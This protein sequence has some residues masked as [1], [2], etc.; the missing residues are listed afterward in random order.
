MRSDLL[1]RRLRGATAMTV[2]FAAALALGGR[3]P[4]A[5]E[6]VPLGAERLVNTT[7]V[8]S[9]FAPA[10]AGEPGGVYLV[11]WQS[12]S[13]DGSGA[14]VY[15]RLFEASGSPLTGE[16]AIAQTTVGEQITPAVAWSP[17]GTFLVAWASNGQD[18]SGFGI[19][20][21]RLLATTGQAL[22]N[23]FPVNVT[24]AGSQLAPKVAAQGANFYVVWSGVGASGDTNDVYGR[25]FAA[26][27]A[28]PGAATGEV[29]LNGGVSG[30]Q[31]Q[32]AIAAAASGLVVVWASDGADGSGFGVVARRFDGAFGAL[33]PDIAVPENT[34]Y[35]QSAPA[36]AGFA[37]GGFAV[38]WQRA[39]Q[40]IGSTIGPQ[41]VIALRRFAGNSASG[42]EHQVQN[43]TSHRHEAPAIVGDSE[44]SVTVAWQEH[45]LASGDK[46]VVASRFDG[47]NTPLLL[48]FPL[49][50]AFA[51][52]QIAPALA[53]SAR[54]IAA[55][56][57]FGQDGSSFGVYARRFGV[58]LPPCAADSTTLCL[59]DNRFRVRATYATAAGANGNGRAIALT[60]DSG[61]YWFFDDA[62]VEIVVKAIDACGLA[63]FD[64]FWLFATGLTNV[65]VSLDVVDTW[66]GDER[67]YRNPLNQDFQPI[68]DTG[69]FDV[70]DAPAPLATTQ[71]TSTTARGGSS[72]KRGHVAGPRWDANQQLPRPRYVSPVLADRT[73]SGAGPTAATNAIATGSCIAN[74]TTLCLNQ[75]RFEVKIDY[76]TAAGASGD[77]Q[78]YPLT[79]DSGY[80]WFF[81]DANVEL[82]IKVIDGCGY[83]DRYWV[84][85]GGLTNVETH[86]TVRDTLHPTAVFQ[87]TNPL[88]QAFAP[89]LSIDAFDTCP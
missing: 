79:T 80:F 78:A 82:V 48:D 36:V 86:L 56:A 65:E 77:G 85:A 43:E 12:A 69:H 89:I 45:D 53:G 71:S 38:A 40:E 3:A 6:L 1:L 42:A 84:F 25:G 22:G 18:G 49:S 23:E 66:T 61:Y 8:G 30:N 87:K 83:N 46:Q 15:G 57:S 41:P 47:A 67:L 50:A 16:L 81:D 63:G 2:A 62:N 11:V 20:A 19:Y 32:P 52:D 70:C 10:V 64:N 14:G 54:L 74:A 29:R 24:T 37:D 34:L 27:G 35:D 73:P 59:N 60:P 21:R 68:L 26:T 4:L 55:W 9:Q 13:Q 72:L 58:P 88:N 44:G 5:A 28:G 33:S 76:R 51:G 39:L 75:G 7:T 17:A 31:V